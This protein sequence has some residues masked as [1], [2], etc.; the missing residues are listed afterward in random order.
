VCHC[1]FSVIARDG[2]G[3]LRSGFMVCI[4]DL[5]GGADSLRAL[6]DDYKLAADLTPSPFP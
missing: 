6:R 5:T 3:S 2:A 4:E 1:F